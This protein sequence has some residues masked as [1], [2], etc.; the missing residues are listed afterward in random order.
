MSA[1]AFILIETMVG[2]TKE[3]A[4]DLKPLEGV[5][6]VDRVTGPYDIIAVIEKESLI[7][8][9]DLVTSRIQNVPSI[10]RV[11]ACLAESHHQT[12]IPMPL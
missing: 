9:C 11:V 6:S 1:K 10:A 12:F 8:V 4:N 5:I 7:G 3:V 2:R